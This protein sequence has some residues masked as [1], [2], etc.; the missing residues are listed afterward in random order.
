MALQLSL[1]Y[2]L[3]L[4]KVS[5]HDIERIR[6]AISALSISLQNCYMSDLNQ[7]FTVYDFQFL[8]LNVDFLEKPS[9]SQ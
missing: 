5:I 6:C 9:K 8:P 4:K 2:L 1:D 7:D 3:E